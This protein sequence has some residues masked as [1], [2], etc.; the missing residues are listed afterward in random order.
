MG[1]QYRGFGVPSPSFE[2]DV[3]GKRGKLPT[4]WQG[5]SVVW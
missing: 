3:A 1:S 4:A 5:L 2:I